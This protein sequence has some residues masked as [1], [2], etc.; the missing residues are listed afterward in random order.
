MMTRNANGKDE[1]PTKVTFRSQRSDVYVAT[2]SERLSGVTQGLFK[3]GSYLQ[4]RSKC[5][6]VPLVVEILLFR[7]ELCF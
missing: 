7:T 4:V 6:I 2:G 1:P 3:R 5:L